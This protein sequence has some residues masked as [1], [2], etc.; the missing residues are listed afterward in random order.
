MG[1]T[2][3]RRERAEFRA[4]IEL[5]CGS[6]LPQLFP[7]AGGGTRPDEAAGETCG[8]FETCHL[9]AMELDEPSVHRR[10]DIDA[11][12]DSFLQAAMRVV[13]IIEHVSGVSQC[14]KQ[15]DGQG[16]TAANTDLGAILHEVPRVQFY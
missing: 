2:A 8:P 4:R 1:P 5:S 6:Q 14:G 10:R 9:A 12:A 7:R 15:C 11:A 13:R 16:R 3:S